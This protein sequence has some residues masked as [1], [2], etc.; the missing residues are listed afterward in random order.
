M[1]YIKNTSENSVVDDP[2]TGNRFNQKKYK[3]IK[4][5]DSMALSNRNHCAVMA[6]EQCGYLF[7]LN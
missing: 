1:S 5:F 7:N 6:S 4:I 2:S 3:D